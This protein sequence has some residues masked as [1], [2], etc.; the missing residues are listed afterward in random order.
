MGDGFDPDDAPVPSSDS[1]WQRVVTRV[2]Q[3]VVVIKTTGARAFDTESA[4]SAYATGFVVDASLGLILTNRHVLRPGPVVA[5]AVFQNREEVP[6]RA[7]YADP[8]HDFAFFRFDPS[9]VLFMALEEVPLFPEGAQVGLEV[10]VVGNDSGEKLSILSATL[11]R[12]DRDAPKYG[13]KGYNDF[14]TFYVQ[15]ASGTK[16]GSSGSPVVDRNGRAVALNAGSK[17]KGSSAYYLP[18]HRVQRALDRLR[19]TAVP[20]EAR[21]GLGGRERGAKAAEDGEASEGDANAAAAK[22]KNPSLPLTQPWLEPDVPRGTLQ[23]TFAY[24]GFDECRRLGLT[25]DTEARLRE[26]Q[27][28]DA[29]IPPEKGLSAETPPSASPGP[30]FVASAGTGA[31]CVEDTCPGGPGEGALKVGDVLVSVDGSAVTHFVDLEARLDAAVGRSVAMAVERGGARVELSLAVQDLHAPSVTP[32]VMLECAGGIVHA[33]SYQ[34][35]RNFQLPAGS[36]YVAEPG[37]A[38]GLGGVPKHAVVTAL[39]NVATP[40]LERFADVWGRLEEGSKVTLKYFT[41]NERHRV[42][43]ASVRMNVGWFPPPAFLKR[44]WK[45]GVWARTKLLEDTGTLAKNTAN[46]NGRVFGDAK[47]KGDTDDGALEAAEPKKHPRTRKRRE[48]EEEGGLAP[49]G[50]PMSAEDVAVSTEPSLV[51]VQCEI[52]SVALADGVYTRSFEGNGVIMH[53]DPRGT[54]LGLVAVDRNTVPVASCDVTITFASYPHEARGRVAYLHPTHNFALVRYD[55]ASLPAEVQNATRAIRV[56][57]AT[58]G[59]R[60]SSGTTPPRLAP[61]PL[62]SR[63]DEVVLVAL[64]SSTMRSMSRTSTVTDATSSAAIPSADIPRFRAVN[65]EVMQ[66]DVDLGY[67]AGGVLCERTTGAMVAV[68]ASYAK[69]TPNGEVTDILRGAGVEPIA[70]A[71]D[72]IVRFASGSGKKT[73]ASAAP[74]RV[75]LLDAE[76]APV[77]LAKAE[78]LGVSRAWIEKMLEADPSRRQALTVASVVAGTGAARSLKGGDVVLTAGG[79]VAPS[80]PAME[81]AVANASREYSTRRNSKTKTKTKRGGREESL[82]EDDRTSGGPAPPPV[83]AVKVLRSG[84]IVDVDVELSEASCAGTARLLHW[85]GCCLQSTHRPVAELGFVPTEEEG[86]EGGGGGGGGDGDARPLDVFI[87]RWYHGSPAQRYGLYALHWV[88]SVNGVPTP[89]L[90][91]FVAATRPVEDGAFARLELVSLTGRPKVVSVKMDLH[92]WPT[93][94]LRRKEDGSDEWERVEIE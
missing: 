38:L 94:E 34:Q 20:P 48:R 91:A 1:R 71:V 70:R 88:R 52:A 36:V 75:T 19:A 67:D 63:G 53:H 60:S 87:S 90:D 78:T 21:E 50:G 33:L 14:N 26:A 15:A 22:R 82:N 74:R 40:T 81:R 29:E 6:L 80:F 83:L 46:R 47:E 17:T 35:A 10:R 24:K 25:R 54:G 92:Y 66:I 45:T 61:E 55:A 72:E 11:A 86:G 89:T 4:S 5:E 23:T 41:N 32:D 39:D 58:T 8:V 42:K 12:I 93:W 3:A 85:G 43:T 37:Y 13:S 30:S 64:S 27:A 18:L 16:G 84:E 7:L 49:D 69:P 44:D 73:F 57:E 9:A 31:L 62:V 51:L 28:T 76:L 2:S 59:R 77:T 56:A 68:W 65:E 79:D